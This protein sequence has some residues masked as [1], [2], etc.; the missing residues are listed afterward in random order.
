MDVLTGYAAAID[1]GGDQDC[2]VQLL[3]HLGAQR[4]TSAKKL[5]KAI[6]KNGQ[7]VRRDLKKVAN[8]LDRLLCV[9]ADG[10]CDPTPAA[11][12]AT[13]TALTLQSELATTPA[14]LGRQ[15]LHPYRLKVK[16]LRNLLQLA[17]NQPDK[18]FVDAL[19][20]LKDAIGEWHDWGELVG[21]A[22]KV[23]HHASNC[24]LIRELKTIT[25]RKFQSALADAETMRRKYLRAS[26]SRRKGS[27]RVRLPA[28]TAFLPKAS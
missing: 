27:N 26:A 15:N 23:L 19:G 12:Q 22:E 9:R 1:A 28:V 4:H 2:K 3:E 8:E 16:E 25:S 20:N 13:A 14:H 17:E 5:H 6:A 24:N 18:E 7:S 10:D 21:T 11:A